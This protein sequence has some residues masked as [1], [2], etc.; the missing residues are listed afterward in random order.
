MG[1]LIDP[2]RFPKTVTYQ[3]KAEN[4]AGASSYSFTSQPIGAAQADRYVI[5]G[6]G[7]ANLGPSITSV[8]I[9]G[10]AATQVA[11]NANANGSSALYIALVP[12]GTTA[13]IAINF[14]STTLLHCGI[15]IW[16]ATGLTST[17]PV[18]FGNSSASATPSVALTTVEGG[19]AIAY[20]HV[21]S[22]V[23]YSNTT[24][25]WSGVVADFPGNVITNNRPHGA[26]HVSTTAAGVTPQ[27]TF[28]GGNGSLVAAAW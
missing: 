5:V 8:T 22:N 28:V 23:N 15:A 1:M 20:A 2:Y 21:G 18:S 3:G 24:V 10:V 25:S 4:T 26:G 6:I 16:S 19:F 13:T 12:T 7:W 27:S 9:G 14:S 17:T 11:L